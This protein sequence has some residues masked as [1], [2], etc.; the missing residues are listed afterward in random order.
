MFSDFLMEVLLL[1]QG[2]KISETEAMIHKMSLPQEQSFVGSWETFLKTV[3]K[4]GDYIFTFDARNKMIEAVDSLLDTIDR[5]KRE[6][7]Q[8][9]FNYELSWRQE[10]VLSNA[11]C[12][13]ASDDR[14]L[15]SDSDRFLR[16][17]SAFEIIFEIFTRNSLRC[18][19][20][21]RALRWGKRGLGAVHISTRC[22]PRGGLQ[23]AHL[24]GHKLDG[25]GGG[26]HRGAHVR[27]VHDQFIRARA[28]GRLRGWGR[29]YC[30][31]Y[32]GLSALASGW[33]STGGSGSAW[34]LAWSR[35]VSVPLATRLAVSVIK[36]VPAILPSISCSRLSKS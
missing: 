28:H 32:T 33:S 34:G 10:V 30:R 20:Q 16:L 4:P 2:R 8:N 25:G 17:W 14:W 21:H 36:S 31:S 7:T 3:V 26:S 24:R 27:R 35:G 22:L 23:N 13:I 5:V 15:T 6:I 1:R 18:Q 12:F 19:D 11:R 9:P 29:L